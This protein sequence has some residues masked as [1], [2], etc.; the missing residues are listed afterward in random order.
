VSFKYSNRG[1][2]AYQLELLG[3]SV[4]Q[5]VLMSEREAALNPVPEFDEA[6]DALS[7]TSSAVY[8]R[9]MERPDML[10]YLQGAS[11]LEE[12]SLLNLGS[13][14]ARRTQA[15]TLSD[16]RAI[17]WV[18]AWTQNRHLL[19]GWYGLGSGLRAFVDV[20]GDRGRRLLRRMFEES[21]LFRLIIDEVERTLLYVDLGIAR[22]FSHLVADAT[23][24]DAVY[25]EIAREYHLPVAMVLEI[26]EAGELAERF[27]RFRRRLARR[28]AAINQVSRSQIGLLHELRTTGS[29]EART[30][31][32]LSINCAAAGLGATG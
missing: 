18:F 12:F 14:P 20:R 16:L 19:P 25:A 7:G 11:P 22:E 24:R 26:T 30:T 31:L 1:T 10:T 21:R 13:R 2:A 27:P 9:L 32:L 17:P 28:L 23:I 6:M 3:A 15:N 8:R 5:H 4:L 29:D